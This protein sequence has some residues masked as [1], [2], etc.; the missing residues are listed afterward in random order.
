MDLFAWATSDPKLAAYMIFGILIL[1][2]LGLPLPEDILLIA[3]GYLWYN[4]AIHYAT[5]FGFAFVGVIIGDSLLYLVGRTIGPNLFNHKILLKLISPRKINRAKARFRLY[6]LWAVFFGR[7]VVGVRSV[8]FFT[9]GATRVPYFRYI[10]ADFLAAIASIPFW[11]ILGFIFGHH[12]EKLIDY[13]KQ[14]KMIAFWGLLGII[15]GY[16][17]F[18]QITNKVRKYRK[19]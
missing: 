5:A 17:I 4:G 3:L 13:I 9:A 7:F 10:W 19:N 12:I 15:G 6:G 14:G 16:L 1:C 8:V 11:I 18:H 2:G